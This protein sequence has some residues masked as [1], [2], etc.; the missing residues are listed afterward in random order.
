MIS[1]AVILTCCIATWNVVYAESFQIGLP[2]RVRGD[3]YYPRVSKHPATSN[4]DVVTEDKDTEESTQNDKTSKLT[5][6]AKIKLTSQPL[7]LKEG[8]E[9]LQRFFQLPE[10][11]NLLVTAGGKR[12]CDEIELTPELVQEWKTAC[13]GVAA[14]QTPNENDTAVLVKTGGIDLPGLHLVSL[15]KIGVK[16]IE[17]TEARSPQYEMTLIGDERTVKG[18]PPVVWIF[19]KLTGASSGGEGGTTTKSLTTVRYEITDN[20]KVVFQTDSFLS[21]T[22]KFPAVLLKILP[23]N[24]EKAEETGSKAITKAVQKDLEASMKSFEE[25]YLKWI[26]N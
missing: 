1:K 7:P 25:A 22:V 8:E 12:P 21:I 4:D 18:L 20:S 17:K 19:N 2:H 13:E 5:L 16:L 11:R 24:K 15:T 14:S 9:Q 10:H 26:D 6:A 3:H 23:T